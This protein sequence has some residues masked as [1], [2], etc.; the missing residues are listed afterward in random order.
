MERLFE[1]VTSDLLQARVKKK[2]ILRL[3]QQNKPIKAQK[4][5]ASHLPLQQL[6]DADEPKHCQ[7]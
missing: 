1:M 3:L 4:G 6:Q 2:E 5:S 7:Q